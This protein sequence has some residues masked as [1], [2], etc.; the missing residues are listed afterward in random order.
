MNYQTF[1]LRNFRDI[2]QLKSFTEGELFDIEVVGNILPFKTNNYIID[3]LIDWDNYADDPMFCLNF[4]QRDMLSPEHFEAI[5]EL[6]RSGA[7]KGE[8]S[9]KANEIRADLNP[10]PAGQLEYNV[11]EYQGEIL[12]GAQHKYRETILFFPKQGQTCH[13]YCTFCFRWPQFTG[14][15]DLKFATK[16][17]DHLVGYL[18][19]HP[20]ITDLLITG[21]DPMVMNAK[22]FSVYIDA[23]LEADLPHLKNIRIGTKTLAFW[24]Y[25]Y[26]TDPDADDMLNV[27]RK[28]VDHGMHLAFMAHVSHPVELSTDVVKKA[29]ANIR[30][31]GAQIRTQSP[32]M[33]HINA[34]PHVWSDMWT[35][36]VQLGMVPYYMFIARDTGA[37]DYFSIPLVDTWKIFRQAYTEVSGIC[38]TVRGP[39]MSANPGKVQIVGVSEINGEKVFVLN[40]LQAR[41]KEWVG[42]P[43]FAAY[44]EHAE[45]LSDLRPAFGESEFFYT[46]EFRKMLNINDDSMGIFAEE[47]R[48]CY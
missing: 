42:H 38:R 47:L 22:N 5:A 40:F 11:P 19:E 33:N 20:E 23:L 17:T 9:K 46:A 1:T 13:A 12:Q 16:Q 4:P 28:I 2:P 48:K 32:I 26:V 45:W 31:T 35:K 7:D 27:F 37:K 6:I 15:S 34:D 8:I 29:I 10:H 24:P 36:Q 39:S 3:E 43:F 21:G 18:R 41:K 44:D 25:R 14:L 30:A